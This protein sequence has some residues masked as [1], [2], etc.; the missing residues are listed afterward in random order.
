VTVGA[1]QDGVITATDGRV[2][3][4]A[5]VRYLSHGYA[6][7]SHKSQSKTVDH[8]IV[9][10]ERLNQKSAY[11]ACSR[12]RL[13][14]SVHVP[15]KTNLLAWLSDGER[16]AAIEVMRKNTRGDAVHPRDKAWAALNRTR[17]PARTPL[18]RA[19]SFE[20]WR[21]TLRGWCHLIPGPSHHNTIRQDHTR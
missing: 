20:W 10:A 13:S 16:P 5:R 4:T 11:V 14:C 6:V 9:A 8:V 2:I 17:A 7:T 15:D 12:G 18:Q 3:D 19:M 1:I 21:E